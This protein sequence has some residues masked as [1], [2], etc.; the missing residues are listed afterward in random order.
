MIIRVV[1]TIAIV[2][3]NGRTWQ[4]ARGN[5]RTCLK[6]FSSNVYEIMNNTTTTTTA[7]TNNNNGNNNNN[8]RTVSFQNFMLVFAA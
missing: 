8:Q 5:G 4:E 2:K 6:L 3:V 7:A 1:I